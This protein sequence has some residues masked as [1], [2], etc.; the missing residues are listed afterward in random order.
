M[1]NSLEFK[2]AWK[3]W[4]KH[5]QERLG[6]PYTETAEQ[7]ALSVLFKE[8]HGIEDLAIKS[9]DESISNNWAKIYII[10]NYNNGTGQANSNGTGA[11]Y[12]DSVKEEFNRRYGAG[13]QATS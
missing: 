9:I 2:A 4:K 8:S 5:K 11:G 12:R 6:S 13:K 7:R 3:D 1:Y 10:K